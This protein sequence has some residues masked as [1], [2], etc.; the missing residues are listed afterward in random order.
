[1]GKQFRL[2]WSFKVGP[3]EGRNGVLLSGEDKV[4]YKEGPWPRLERDGSA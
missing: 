1:M 2:G 4:G 3:Q